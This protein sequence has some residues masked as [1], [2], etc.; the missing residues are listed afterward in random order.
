MY[1]IRRVA[2]V[3]LATAVSGP[4]VAQ[5]P[6]TDPLT[7]AT[8]EYNRDRKR[9]IAENLQLTVLEAGRFWPLYEKFEK[10]LFVLTEKRRAIIAEFGENYDEMSD[11]MAGKILADRLELE[12][13]LAR[14]RKAYLPR[15]EKILPIKKLARYYQIESKIRASVDAGIAEE[16]PLIK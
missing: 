7:E 5:E 8:Q 2:A 10:D 6:A 12:E 4:I 16:I 14:L 11:A 1:S 3:L 15:F 13:D 9:L